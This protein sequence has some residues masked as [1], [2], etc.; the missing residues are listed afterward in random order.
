MVGQAG[1]LSG[2]PLRDLSLKTVRDFYALTDGNIPIIGC[3]GI[4]SGKDAVAFARAGAS[5]VQVYTAMGYEGPGI[6][7]RIKDE[8][9]E[10]LD[11]TW[12]DVIGSDH[13]KKE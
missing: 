3:G 8:V 7:G 13:R 2:A 12:E 1:G 10:E 9:L 4:S 5:A 11:G 6:V